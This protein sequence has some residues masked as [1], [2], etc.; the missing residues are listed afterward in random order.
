MTISAQSRRPPTGRS[1]TPA[2]CVERGVNQS[3]YV[4]AIGVHGNDVWLEVSPAQ[5]RDTDIVVGARLESP[6]AG[7]QIGGRLFVLAVHTDG[8]ESSQVFAVG[9]AKPKGD[10]RQGAN[11]I[12]FTDGNAPSIPPSHPIDWHTIHCSPIVLLGIF[13]PSGIASPG[14][15]M[16]IANGKVSGQT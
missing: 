6:A 11:D 7:F 3:Q 16:R 12:V 15:S 9:L 14:F 2:A 8:S 10:G 5:R 13:T 1:H 4:Y